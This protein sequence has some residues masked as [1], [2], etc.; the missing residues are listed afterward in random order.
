MDN[1]I[2]PE[3]LEELYKE[4]HAAIRADPGHEK[5][6]RAKKGSAM[7]WKTPKLTHAERRAKLVAKLTALKEGE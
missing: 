2:D 5:K 6:E 4:V 3:E 7:R 1:D